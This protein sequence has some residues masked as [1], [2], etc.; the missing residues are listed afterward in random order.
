MAPE[1]S[2]PFNGQ[3]LTALRHV[4]ALTQTALA[5]RLDVTQ[6]FLSQVERGARPVPDPLVVEASTKFGLPIAFFAVR[7]TGLEAGPMT[8]RKTSRASAKDEGRVSE[9]YNEAARLFRRVSAGSGYQTADLPDPSEYGDDP[10]EVASAMRRA[11][12]LGSDD[13]VLNAT[14]T[15]ERFGIGVV[16]RLDR[17]GHDGGHT[18]VSRP[19]RLSDRPLVAL[20][21]D[22]PGAVK[23]LTL[24]HEFYHLIADRD[25]AA[26]ITSTRSPEEQRAF[27]FA[28]AFLLPEQVVR[29]RVSETLSL[30]GYLPIKADYGISAGAIIRRAR[31]LGVISADRY[32]SLSIQLSSAGW[33]TNEP[34]EVADEKPLLLGQALRK[35]FGN[36][37]IAR[38]SHVVGS[39]PEWIHRW[40]HTADG[41]PD[42]SPSNV[43]GL[44][45]RR[46]RLK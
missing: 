44:A 40:T 43:V 29:Q 1:S 38:A 4:F 7:P 3:R 16:D 26:P 6:S 39:A 30:H 8:F 17:M 36:Q 9:L 46:E 10:E 25:L 18:G 33:R 2:P 37:A 11:A 12:G 34:V 41:Q 31:D 14:R 28:G 21:D 13:P 27:R 32:R 19:S 22:V 45:E 20:A 35:A 42:E 5:E 15:L 24:L 23:R